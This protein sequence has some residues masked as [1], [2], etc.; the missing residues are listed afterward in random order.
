MC[1]RAFGRIGETIDWMH[2]GWD[3]WL[4][5]ALP[6]AAASLLVLAPSAAAAPAPTQ[7]TLAGPSKPVSAGSRAKL[8]ARLTSAGQPVKDKRIEFLSGTTAVGSATTDSKGRATKRVKLTGSASFVARY[9][10]A[11]A[12]APALAPAQSGAVQ[13]IPAARVSVGIASYLR[14]GPRAVGVP[15]APVR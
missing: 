11:A 10:P 14:A 7:L 4:R 6:V 5:G 15:G 1:G 13:L 8:T 3:S 9:T 12:D 2:G